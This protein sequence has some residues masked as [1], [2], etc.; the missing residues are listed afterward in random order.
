MDMGSRKLGR[1]VGGLL[2]M[3]LLLVACGSGEEAQ[4]TAAQA[5]D[6]ATV[7]PAPRGAEPGDAGATPAPQ[8]PGGEEDADP[9][10]TPGSEDGEEDDGEP[11]PT[12][13]PL[14]I[15]AELAHACVQS[16][17]TQTLRVRTE[18]WSGVAFEAIYSDGK[19]GA[20]PP[21]GEGY[22]GNDGALAREDG[23][24]EF[25]WQIS[26]DAPTGEVDVVVKAVKNGYSPGEEV[27]TFTLRSA[28]DPCL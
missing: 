5:R 11:T 12:P 20:D 26:T 2:A 19:S 23:R 24:A 16:G 28:T 13:D 18:P 3:G 8:G 27:E 22:G 4:Q 21:Y 17:G 25:T 14:P 7:T 6:R 9:S 10:P 1:L 15:E